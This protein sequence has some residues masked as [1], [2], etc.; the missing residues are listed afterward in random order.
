MVGSKR[1]QSTI[2]R[3]A[4]FLDYIEKAR[5]VTDKPLMLTG[6]FRTVSVME[7]A[8][9]KG[10]L[11]VVGLGR[12]FCLYPEIAQDIFTKKS[13]SFE[14]S[15][16]KSGIKFIDKTGGVELPWYELQIHRIGKGKVPK[17]SISGLSAFIFSIKNM[18][19]K[20]FSKN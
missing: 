18:I 4:Y 13:T 17:I 14:V 6:G 15:A 2:E 11:D 1:K 5:R 19:L 10:A 12:P 16:P 20:S 8:L 9:E 7:T 3:E